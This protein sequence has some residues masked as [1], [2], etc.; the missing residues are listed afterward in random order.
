LEV[1]VSMEQA[2]VANE[3]DSSSQYLPVRVLLLSLLAV[4][5]LSLWLF[6]PALANGFVNWDDQ[7]YVEELVRMGKFSLSSLGW[8]WTSLQPFYL[9]PV[10]WMTHLLDYQLW[11][12][13]P[14]GH[15]ATNWLLHGV[16][17]VLV[18]TL[19]WM[20][21]GKTRDIRSPERLM[22]SLGIAL[23]CGIHPLQ[24]ESVAWISARNGLLCSVW[25]VAVLCA[26]LLAV[27][28]TQNRRG[29]WWTAVALHAIA[30]LTKPFA[31]S[32]PLLM[33][34]IDFFPLRR[35]ER[36]GWWRLVREKWLLLVFSA[37]AAI[38]AVAAQER[39]EGLGDY[40]LGARLLVASRG[41]VFYLWKFIWP[42]WL[43]PFYPLQSTVEL[44][45]AEF[46][47]PLAACILVTVVAVWQRGR[48]PLLAASWWSYVV[49][50]LPV[51]GLMQV[52]GQ[53][54]A[55]RYAYLAMVPVLLALSGST[56]WLWRRSWVI[57]KIL[58]CAVVSAWLVF[59]AFRTRQQIPV[60][61]DGLSLW[62]AVLTRF[63]NDPRANFNLTMAL[64]GA[65]RLSEARPFAER[66]VN[67]SDPRTP[68][69]PVARATL[70][71]IYLK[72]HVY[73]AAIEQLQQALQADQTLW[74]A[75]YNL[76]CAYTRLGRLSEA[77]DVLQELFATHPEYVALA[78]RDGELVA[79][80][81]DPRYAARFA[82]MVAAA[83]KR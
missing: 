27:G 59:L 7:G 31:V 76:A 64:V 44:R 5:V 16:Y 52:G 29:W 22:M 48:A 79:L 32:L 39:L 75:R 49:L 21:A 47:V 65:G 62:S 67:S 63:P 9:Q 34:A 4:S 45:N 82:G 71:M 73:S 46:L 37:L 56:K 78:A 23:V 33:L 42:G 58:A 40:R 6:R 72:T 74:T 25:M 30:L 12:L 3:T 53:A 1:L 10:A 26:Y 54:V 20:L 43:S 77:C 15:H 11:G 38:G 57:T 51:S 18:G 36:N 19:V 14:V 68:Q 69:L 81:S 24:V 13:N 2:P 8:M 17:V 80:R 61:H 55:D 28:G 66:A 83:R 50:L 41:L 70:G 35:Y 60:W